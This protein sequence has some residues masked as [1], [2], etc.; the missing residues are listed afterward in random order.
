VAGSEECELL[1][2]ATGRGVLVTARWAG[3]DSRVGWLTSN[4]AERLRDGPSPAEVDT[5][6]GL[7][8]GKGEPSGLLSVMVFE[9]HGA[10]LSVRGVASPGV[11]ADEPPE[12]GASAELRARVMVGAA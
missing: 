10:E 9:V 5:R 11:V 8:C 6:L 3:H 4:G 12:D 1:G 2:Y 7:S